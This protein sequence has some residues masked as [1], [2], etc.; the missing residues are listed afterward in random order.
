MLIGP[1][2]YKFVGK[3][4]RITFTPCSNLLSS[5]VS[6]SLLLWLKKTSFLKKH[7][8]SRPLL[9]RLRFIVK[10]NVKTLALSFLTM[11]VNSVVFRFAWEKTKEEVWD[12]SVIR[13]ISDSA[14]TP[15]KIAKVL[16]LH[17]TSARPPHL[18]GDL[19]TVHFLSYPL[20]PTIT[21]LIEHFSLIKNKS[22]MIYF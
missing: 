20:V 1:K 14:S 8:P 16:L 2:G 18:V 15:L 7:S 22:F 19:E 3:L 11:G 5:F 10:E 17:V 4:Q 9:Q 6:F 12:Y 13:P 21:S